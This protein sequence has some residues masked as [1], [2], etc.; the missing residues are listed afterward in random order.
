MLKSVVLQ[1][2][3]SVN[4]AVKRTLALRYTVC[5]H[6]AMAVNTDDER[7]DDARMQVA[8]SQRISAQ[9]SP[10]YLSASSME[11]KQYQGSSTTR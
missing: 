7:F 3:S 2:Q 10:A 11:F 1:A 6:I 5:E 8:R 4:F 9:T